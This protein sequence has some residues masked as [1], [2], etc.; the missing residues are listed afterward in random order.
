MNGIVVGDVLDHYDRWPVPTVIISDGAYGVGGFPGDPRRAADLPGWYTR[1]LLAWARHATPQTTL[2]FWGTE[3][4]WAT[5]HAAILATGWEYGGCHVWDKGIAHVAGNVNSRTIRS[6]PVAT[7]VCVRYTRRVVLPFFGRAL[8]LQEWLRVEWGRTGLPFR[9]ANDAC[10]VADAATRK[11]LTTDWRWYSPPPEM[12]DR[13]AAYANE[14]GDPRRRPYFA[15]EGRWADLRAKWHHAHGL[16]NVWREPALRSAE[17]MR[18]DRGKIVHAN[19]K[20]LALMARIVAASSDPGDV[21]W[22]PFGGLATG[23]LAAARLGRVGY[24]AESNAAIHAV[25][26]ARISREA[27]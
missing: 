15:I 9:L 7:E 25:A 3:E 26:S 19:Q 12:F 13:L 21:V 17:R 5:M 1:H 14:H 6:S 16:T 23:I 20:P 11:Y 4:G 2:W 10:G 22:E 8:G 18:D 27:P 24:A